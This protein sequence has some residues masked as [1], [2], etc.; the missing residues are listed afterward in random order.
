MA[1]RKKKEEEVEVVK[2]TEEVLVL[3]ANKPLDKGQ[4]NLLSELVKEE[5]EKSGVKIVLIPHSVDVVEEK[6]EE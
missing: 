4:F 3:K 5:E 6:E 2:E 1:A